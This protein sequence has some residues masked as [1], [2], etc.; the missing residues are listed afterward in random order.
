MKQNEYFECDEF[1]APVIRE[2]NKRGYYT[3][4]CC[5]GHI[6]G[7]TNHYGYANKHN[8]IKFNKEYKKAKR[9]ANEIDADFIIDR[10]SNKDDGIVSFFVGYN[11][12]RQ[13]Y[14]MFDSVIKLPSIPDG[15]FVDDD[16][17]GLVIRHNFT[18]ESSN[19]YNRINEIINTM[20]KLY[21]WATK[22]PARK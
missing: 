12:T 16:Y 11:C 14:I 5:S 17:T 9:C 20:S 10:R 13:A 8:Q 19:P 1:I 15:W 7:E 22:L 21:S 4:F 3:Q 18:S 6:F 2:L